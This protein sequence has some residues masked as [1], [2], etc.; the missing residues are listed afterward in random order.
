MLAARGEG[1]C[2]QPQLAAV[3]GTGCCSLVA[4]T[5]I[6]NNSN[7]LLIKDSVWG[8]IK[9]TQSMDESKQPIVPS[10]KLSGFW[11]RKWLDLID[12]STSHKYACQSFFCFLSA[13]SVTGTPRNQDA[14]NKR[15][16]EIWRALPAPTGLPKLFHMAHAHFRIHV[17]HE[18]W[19]RPN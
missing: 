10:N 15:S 19:C 12:V 11:V 6:V 1:S 14:P 9:N 5:I 17:P 18:L 16:E 7:I 2:R 13:E 4:W 3:G 8:V